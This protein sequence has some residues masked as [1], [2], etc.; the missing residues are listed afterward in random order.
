MTR[1]NIVLTGMPGSGKSTIGVILAKELCMDF[2]DTDELIQSREGMT[3]QEIIDTTGQEAFVELEK[4]YIMEL[5][6]AGTVI[7]PGGSVVLYE[8]A[9]SSLKQSGTV[10]FLHVPIDI[11]T[12]RINL[13][14]RGT[15]RNPGETLD[16]VWRYRKPLYRKYAD[17]IIDCGRME[18]MEI[19]LRIIAKV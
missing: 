8:D 6:V 4:K 14:D 12:P 5:D 16:D 3:L 17:V 1:K 7:A 18:Q 11:I 15:V 13:L 10:V 2:V 9:I 19:V